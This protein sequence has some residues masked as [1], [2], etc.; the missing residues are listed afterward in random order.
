MQKPKGMA[1]AV[2]VGR[3]GNSGAYCLVSEEVHVITLEIG[4]LLMLTTADTAL[5]V[6]IYVRVSTD[7]QADNFSIP[8]QLELLRS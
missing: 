6:A 1:P 2:C 8:A 5:T 4:S 7:E 3:Q